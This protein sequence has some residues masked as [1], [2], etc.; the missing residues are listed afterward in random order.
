LFRVSILRVTYKFLLHVQ[1]LAFIT[2][3]LKFM[4]TI[5]L[6]YCPII[7]CEAPYN[8]AGEDNRHSKQWK[9][10]PQSPFNIDHTVTWTANCPV[11]T[12][13]LTPN[14][15]LRLFKTADRKDQVTK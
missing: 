4:H 2:Q 7:S 10:T 1:I 11:T 5:F 13:Y 8:W 12:G 3:F 9:S 6:L 14:S 15:L